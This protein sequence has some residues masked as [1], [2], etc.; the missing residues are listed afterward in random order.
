MFRVPEVKTTSAKVQ[1]FTTLRPLLGAMYKEFQELSKKKQ[2]GAISA[3]KVKMVNRLLSAVHKL[4][5]GEPNRGYLDLLDEDD[6]PQNSDVVLI[7]S[8]TEAAMNAYSARY[9]YWN[10]SDHVWAV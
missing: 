6:L 3:T 8:Q 10:G 1:E 5:E 7:L 9:N 2:D 4:L